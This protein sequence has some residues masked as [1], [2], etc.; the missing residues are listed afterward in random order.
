MFLLRFLLAF[1]MLFSTPLAFSQ[2]GQDEPAE[3]EQT[4]NQDSE[5]DEEE[6]EESSNQAEQNNTKSYEKVQVT[7]SLIR[8]A[9]FEGPS[10]IQIIDRKSIEESSY[11]SV[12][13][14]VRDQPT[15]TFG[16]TREASGSTAAGVA[17]INLRGLGASNTLVLLNNMRLPRDANSGIVDMN[18]IPEIAID[19][20]TILKDG[21]SATYGSDAIGGVVNLITRKNFTGTELSAKQTLTEDKGGNRTDIGVIT[22]KQ[23][24]E[25]GP[26]QSGSVTAAV[27]YRYNERI[28]DRDRPWSRPSSVASGKNIGWS[29]IG[30]VAN[31]APYEDTNADGEK[32]FSDSYNFF[33]AQCS[34]A[35]RKIFEQSPPGTGRQCGYPFAN[36]S[37]QLPKLQQV[38][39]YLNTELVLDSRNTFDFTALAT[40]KQIEWVYAPS[41]GQ[42]SSGFIIPASTADTINPNTNGP[43]PGITPGTDVGFNY[44]TTEFGNRK[45][46]T[47]SMS[48]NLMSSYKREF[49]ETAQWN[50]SVAFSYNDKDSQGVS[51]YALATPFIAAVQSG[52][53]NVFDPNRD[54]SVLGN[55]EHKPF[56]RTRSSTLIVDSNVNGELFTRGQNVFAGAFG[57]QYFH[58]EYKD[59]ADPE[60]L[61]SLKPDGSIRSDVFGSAASAGGGSRDV[62]AIYGE[63]GYNYGPKYEVQLAARYDKYSDF[64]DSFIP[65][66]GVKY[67]PTDTVMLRASASK[68]FKAPIL[69]A[70]YATKTEGNPSYIDFVACQNAGN[71]PNAE[72][73]KSQ[74]RRNVTQGN[75]GLEEE[76]AT[77]YGVG[78]IYEPMQGLV[79]GVDY[80]A[81]DQE[82]IVGTNIQEMTRAESQGRINPNDIPNVSVNRDPNAPNE[83]IFTEIPSLNIGKRFQDGVDFD[84]AYRFSTGFGNFSVNN[85]YSYIFNL[86][87]IG[88][89]GA[90]ERNFIDNYGSPHWRNL[91]SVNYAPTSN[92]AFTVSLNSTAGQMNLAEVG[93]IPSFNRVDLSYTGRI[94]WWEGGVFTA[95]INNVLNEIPPYDDIYGGP[96][97]FNSSLYS[98]LNRHIYVS[99]RHMF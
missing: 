68:A 1:A 67:R 9:D 31:Y 85:T 93:R 27:Q 29:T 47:E 60:S 16:A 59:S 79:F 51:G 73:C 57:L 3:V 99:Y 42:Q 37:D 25:F 72:E 5:T 89:P 94:P 83:I 80:W 28:W 23:F 18:L 46:E 74:Q 36:Q 98:Q 34:P 40:V 81:V 33:P 30:P 71:N 61:P 86:K 90:A 32:D 12:A 70:L 56:Q 78:V 13:D 22:G 10:A 96:S 95:G 52:A 62:G 49:N 63:L 54:P 53:Y 24:G 65:K 66:V 75:P 19:N 82:N 21:A 2:E 76:E 97:P 58:E 45:T 84:F 55:V 26:F 35:E 50:N 17:G 15:S 64:G 77:I 88:F 41:P 92:H 7:G 44:R 4:E 39:A 38:S 14:Y 8:R 43:L 91:F 87:S 11:N 20:V 48:V 69:P 6:N